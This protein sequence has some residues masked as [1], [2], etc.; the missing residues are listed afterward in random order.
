M[1]LYRIPDGAQTRWFSFENPTGAKGAAAPENRTA[2][3]HAFDSVAAGQTVTLAEIKSSGE[4]RRMWFTVNERDPQMLRSLRFEIFWDGAEKPAVSVP[5]GD[6]FGAILGK[7]VAFE[8][9]FFCNPEGRSFN[10]IIP[11]PFKTGAKLTLTNDSSRL[12]EKLFYDIDVL[13]TPKPDPDALY[14]HATWRRDLSTKIAQDFELLPR[15][16]GK[17]RFLGVHVGLIGHPDNV[18]WFGEGE[19]KMYIDGDTDL[20]T[21][22]GTGT[23]DYIGTGWGQGK[24]QMRYQGCLVAENQPAEFTFYRYHVPDPVYFYKDIR[25]TL[26]QMGGAPKK[27]VVDLLKKGVEIKPV[28][29]DTD[30]K[31]I[32]LLESDPPIDLL[33]HDSPDDSWVNM[34]RRDDVCATSFFYLDSPTNGLSELSDVASRIAGLPDKP[35]AKP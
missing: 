20:P 12:L 11:M 31:F 17:G 26:Q 8:N 24:F 21:I 18:G 3:G 30:G 14:F 28:S 19:V 25:V 32:K 6:F 34:Y 7:T 22:A 23:E 5:F 4:I 27:Q 16:S 10:C 15:V 13:Q 35:V 1:D 29:I 33:K 2:K 9:E